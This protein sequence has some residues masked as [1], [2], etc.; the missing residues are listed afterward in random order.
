MRVY[1]NNPIGLDTI[2]VLYKIAMFTIEVWDI[3]DEWSVFPIACASMQKMDENDSN[4]YNS[5]DIVV[6]LYYDRDQL[7][8]RRVQT[9]K[10]RCTGQPR[11]P[12]NGIATLP[13]QGEAVRNLNFEPLQW[14]Q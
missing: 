6:K 13:D 4:I 9:S 3:N 10:C 14:F 2:G 12:G 7:M 1:F 8:V 5:I 11:A